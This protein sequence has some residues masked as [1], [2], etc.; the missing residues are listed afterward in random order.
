MNALVLLLILW[1]Q[2]A[3]PPKVVPFVTPLTP[4]EMKNK[5]AV[6]ETKIEVI[7]ARVT[8]PVR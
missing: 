8:G 2:Q 5:Q 4:A 1:C 3:A 6:I 7:R